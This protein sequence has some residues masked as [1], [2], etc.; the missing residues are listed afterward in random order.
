MAGFKKTYQDTIRQLKKELKKTQ[1]E[2]VSSYDTDLFPE[3]IFDISNQELE[4]IKTTQMYKK[5]MPQKHTYVFPVEPYAL[6]RRPVNFFKELELVIPTQ[7]EDRPAVNMDFLT[8]FYL[9]K[10]FILPNVD[11]TKDDSIVR[12]IVSFHAGLSSDGLTRGIW[13]GIVHSQQQ[14]QWHFYG[15]DKYIKDEYKKMYINGVAK[16]CDVFSMNSI[17]GI[18]IQSEELLKINPYDFYTCDV[19]VHTAKDVL[20]SVI[21]SY[22]FIRPHGFGFVRLPD[23]WDK[24]YTQLINVFVYMISTYEIVKIFKTP[25]GKTSKLYML[26]SKPKKGALS[27]ARYASVIKYFDAPD[28]ACLYS[29]IVYNV[30][31]REVKETKDQDEATEVQPEAE[32]QEKSF[33]DNLRDN[34]NETYKQVMKYDKEFT[35]ELANTE[36]IDTVMY[37]PEKS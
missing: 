6:K 25:W 2:H 24:I 3:Y 35:N 5:T 32:L 27:A 16:K 8:G 31:E 19:Q 29:S 11:T 15:C 9:A 37:L 17:R 20:K 34:L 14:L 10:A 36:W 13:Y 18:E 4:P 30:A 33:M 21:L 23:N 22:K 28:A 26:Y 7:F 12:R 1:K